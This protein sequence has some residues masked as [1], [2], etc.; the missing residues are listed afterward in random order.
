MI[1]SRDA[2]INRRRGDLAAGRLSRRRFMASMA[3][4]GVAVPTAL[5]WAT[6]AAGQAAG[7]MPVKGGVLRLGVG[8]GSTT[9]T[10]DPGTFEA[11][12][13][14]IVGFGFGNCLME[15]DRTGQLVPELAQEIASDDA[16]TWVAT[17]RQGVEFSNGKT[18]TP[19][20]VVATMNHHR[21]PESTSAASGLLQSITDIRV[22]G[23]AV[24]FVL[25][26]PNADFPYYLSDYHLII[27]PSEDG[28]LLDH[29]G[30][31]GT[32][33]YVVDRFDP[34]VRVEMS[35]NPNYWK[36]GAAHFD[37]I[38][39]TPVIDG[40]ARQNAMM[41]GNVDVIDRVDPKTVAL[42]ARVPT[43]DI[44]ELTSTTHYTMPMR[45]DSPP[46]DSYD[47]R[48][49][50]KLAVNR[51]EMVDKILLG[52]G[53]LGNDHPI[54]S[55]DVFFNTDLPQRA[56]DPD[57]ARFHYE[58]SGHGG[59]LELSASD[60]AFAG[61]VDAAQLMAASAATAGMDVRVVREPNDG[62][63]TNVWNNKPWCVSYWGGRPTPDWMYASG[64][65]ND[66][67][68]N[69][70]AWRNTDASERFNELVIAARAELDPAL[71]REM[72]WE[73]QA[74]IHDDCGVIVPM[75]ANQ[76]IAVSKDI[77]HAEAVASNYDLD[78]A[79]IAER[80]WRTD[81]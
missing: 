16:K 42:L 14:L 69:E 17:L 55:N 24:V 7:R 73:T 75:F 58:K 52:H 27:L 50:L 65:L 81:G 20:D 62:Y 33:G 15:V 22:D 63:W 77:G 9:D 80:W 5:G 49:A 18:L 34:G 31:I 72:Y 2:F 41:T 78:G 23:N 57:L 51:Q 56:F 60:A 43:L 39:V 71:R 12:F 26:A 13:N 68:W 30:G 25:D 19:Q 29:A 76:I 74:L 61:A 59:P 6:Q 3:A 45:L 8:S 37:R 67:E 11:T 44:L 70:T 10:L 4:A 64:Y 79:K 36:D 53:S 46:F 28:R 66:I 21:G 48:M 40:T 35:R 54:A 32:G 47:L 1:T 38:E